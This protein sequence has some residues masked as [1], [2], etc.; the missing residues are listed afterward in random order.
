MARARHARSRAPGSSGTT[1][2]RCERSSRPTPSSS[3]CAAQPGAAIMRS[4]LKRTRAR[5]RAHTHRHATRH[6]T[7]V[8]RAEDGAQLVESERASEGEWREGAR[9]HTRGLFAP[10][11][12]LAQAEADPSLSRCEYIWEKPAAPVAAGIADVACPNCNAQ[13]C[14]RCFGA[15]HTHARTHAHTRAHPHAHTYAHTHTR[16][17][18]RTHPQGARAQRYA[19]RLHVLRPT[20]T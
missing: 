16:T 6:N 14:A 18:A 10:L 5:A 15:T 20:H 1:G 19:Q 12:D 3:R 4:A 7:Y 2:S 11:R 17:H 13:R 9:T 8:R